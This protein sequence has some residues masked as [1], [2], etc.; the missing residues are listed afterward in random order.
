M[1]PP[2]DFDA[3]ID[4]VKELVNAKFDGVQTQM[5]GIAKTL[6]RVV[7]A[8]EKQAEMHIAVATMGVRIG[9]LE[10]GAASHRNATSSA[11]A[12][13]NKRLEGVE[14]TQNRAAWRWDGSK[15]VLVA[16]GSCVVA[17]GTVVAD[18]FDKIAAF[19]HGA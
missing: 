2:T 14:R 10:E 7:D 15:T 4:A 9:H 19:F 13:H 8:I 3:K 11:F 5:G 17:V 16:L 6:D 12:S 1:P 18:H